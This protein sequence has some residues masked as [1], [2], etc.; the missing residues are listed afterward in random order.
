MTFLGSETNKFK[1]KQCNQTLFNEK[2]L[3]PA[4]DWQNKFSTLHTSEK[5]GGE[6]ART[7]IQLLG[8]LFPEP[9]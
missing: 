3:N 2:P 9:G 1:H 8:N 5:S 4:A 7:F 6:K